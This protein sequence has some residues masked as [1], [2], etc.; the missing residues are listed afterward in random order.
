METGETTRKTA[1]REFQEETGL[2]EWS[3]RDGF[4]EEPDLYLRPSRKQQCSRR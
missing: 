1:A 4:G 3:F 2:V